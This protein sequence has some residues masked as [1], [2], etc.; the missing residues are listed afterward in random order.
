MAKNDI[1]DGIKF[2][3]DVQKQIPYALHLALNKTAWDLRRL[4]KREIVRAFKNPKPFTK[5]AIIYQRSSSKRDLHIALFARDKVTRGTA[6]SEYLKAQ[7]FGNTR[8]RKK[9]EQIMTV[10]SGVKDMRGKYYGMPVNRA[11]SDRFTRAR[12][13]KLVKGAQDKGTPEENRKY[14]FMAKGKAR[15]IWER[16]GRGGKKIRLAMYLTKKRPHYGKRFRFFN[17][18]IRHGERLV[19]KHFA[20]TLQRV[21][22]KE[23]VIDPTT[24]VML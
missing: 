11:K 8:D 7:V 16:Y 23:G 1:L 4:E 19:T 22:R 17:V 10:K 24:S 13:R 9:F 14:F 6:P 12:V 15:G 5:N 20:V 3:R 2:I 21:L 18:G